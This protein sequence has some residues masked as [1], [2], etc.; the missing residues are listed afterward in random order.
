MAERPRASRP[1]APS[2]LS[3]GDASAAGSGPPGL[4][5]RARTDG[6]TAVPH[7]Q[8]PA[9]GDPMPPAFVQVS[10]DAAQAFDEGQMA[11]FAASLDGD[12]EFRGVILLHGPGETPSSA[13]DGPPLLFMGH[14]ESPGGDALPV[15]FLGRFRTETD[16]VQLEIVTVLPSTDACP[17]PLTAGV[18]TV[19]LPRRTP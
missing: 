17:L 11:P 7:A 2:T 10:L 15:S 8:D 19:R 14:A 18:H 1:G 5:S 3:T 4:A 13:M 12:V 16:S 6:P 9:A